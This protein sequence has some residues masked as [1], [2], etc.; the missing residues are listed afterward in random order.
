[1]FSS[2]LSVFKISPYSELSK[3]LQAIH[4]LLDTFAHDKLVDG[5]NS[6]DAAL[7]AVIA[8]LQSEKSKL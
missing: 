4:F 6:R 5:E 7:D 8:L 3:V 1:M 2:L